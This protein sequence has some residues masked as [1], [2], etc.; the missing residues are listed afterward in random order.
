[1]FFLNNEV[2]AQTRQSL[3]DQRIQM[4]KEIEETTLYL[5]QTVQSQ[6]ESGERLNL[7]NVQVSQFNRLISG[8]NAEIA[9]F[10]RQ[11]NE[12]SANVRRMTSEIEKLKEEYAMLVF[13]AYKHRGKF[14]VIIYVLAAKDFNEAY[15]RFKYFQQ[16]SEFR[17][18]QVAEITAR[19]DEMNIVIAT[20]AEQRVEREQ[21]LVEQRQE[22]R[23]LELVQADLN[24]E[25]TALRAQERR[26]RTQLAA[27]QQRV[28]D[29]NNQIQRIVDEEARRRTVTPL[30]PEE[31]LISNNFQ[32]NRGR[33]PWPTER[34]QITSNFGLVCHPVF[35]NVCHTNN[36]VD[37]TT[38]GNSE[39]RAVF[40]GTVQNIGGI[41]G[42]GIWI[43]IKHGEFMTVYS[44]LAETFVRTGDRVQHRERIGR[45]YTEQGAENAVYGFGI[46]N[47][48]SPLNPV[49]WI[50]RN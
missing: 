10:D 14:N 32:E 42:G 41:L 2:K 26:V 44:N 3:E 33:L 38:L 11:I 23:K 37:I 18:R 12:N 19:Q 24:R 8:L 1:M 21:L 22:N 17:K 48:N 46:W 31:R 4:L 9:Y 45:V 40:E 34:G 29:L 36:G 30:T 20:L 27:Q 39:I 15:R 43:I 25:I 47:Q 28:R 50:V 5:N 49:Q 13:Q 35:R 6:R 7:L 16:Y